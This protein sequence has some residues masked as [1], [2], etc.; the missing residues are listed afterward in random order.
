ME[1]MQD[2]E[3]MEVMQDIEDMEQIVEMEDI[4]G[5]YYNGK[6]PHQQQQQQQQQLGYGGDVFGDDNGYW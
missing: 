6:D 4:I 3:E 5:G 1:V 2:M